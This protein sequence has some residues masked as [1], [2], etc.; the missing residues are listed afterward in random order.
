MQNGFFDAGF[1][2]VSEES[3]YSGAN[4]AG[5]V[6]GEEGGFEPCRRGLLCRSFFFFLEALLRLVHHV[7][8]GMDLQA[9]ERLSA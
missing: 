2:G 7:V 5:V 3:A 8:F 4:R 9:S 6:V 1:V